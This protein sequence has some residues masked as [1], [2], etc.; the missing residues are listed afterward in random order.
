M[1]GLVFFL[2]GECMKSKS[3]NGQAMVEFALIL[4]PLLI[5]IG[6]IMDF[7]WVFHQQVIANNVSRETARYLAINYNI[8]DSV[9]LDPDTTAENKVY[10]NIPSYVKDYMD[11]DS[12]QDVT[13]G[14]DTITDSIIVSVAWKTDTLTRLFMKEFTIKST[15]EMMLERAIP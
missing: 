5:I 8:N 15:T 6:G 3:E 13:V 12:L 1:V 9:K 4:I 2:G 10:N 11:A 7:G 14:P